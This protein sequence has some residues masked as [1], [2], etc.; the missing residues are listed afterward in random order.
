MGEMLRNWD[1]MICILFQCESAQ[2]FPQHQ[3]HSFFLFCSLPPTK[4]YNARENPRSWLLFSSVNHFSAKHKAIFRAVFKHVW[5]LVSILESYRPVVPNLGPPD[6]LGLQLPEALTTTSAG[7]DFWELKSKNFWRPKVGDHC[8]NR[9]EQ[10]ESSWKR[11]GREP[12]LLSD[13][14]CPKQ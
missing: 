1:G 3:I 4:W 6:V 14:C 9:K 7:Q 10:M 12:W 2:N 11:A 13:S 8:S 5:M